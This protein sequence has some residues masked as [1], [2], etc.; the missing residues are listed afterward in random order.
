MAGKDVRV[1]NGATRPFHALLRRP[2][3]ASLPIPYVQD[4]HGNA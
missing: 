1:A 4:R 3:V 2:V